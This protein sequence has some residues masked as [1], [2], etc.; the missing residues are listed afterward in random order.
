MFVKDH[1]KRP[2]IYKR[3]LHVRAENPVLYGGNGFRSL[4]YHIF[5]KGLR[6]SGIPRVDEAGTVALAAVGIKGKLRNKQKFSVYILQRK[7]CLS[8]FVFKN[9]K[10]KKLLQISVRG[11]TA[12]V[13]RYSNKNQ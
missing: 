1:R 7:I 3:Y 2:V 12:V 13:V 5:V 8:V 9:P 11:F 6:F 4:L 10:S